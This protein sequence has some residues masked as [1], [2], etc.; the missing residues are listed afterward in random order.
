M[1]TAEKTALFSILTNLLLLSLKAGLA[2]ASGSLAIKADAI[3]SFSDVISSIIILVGIKISQ[4]STPSFPY[5]L[6]KLENL[7][8]L[9]T[10]LLIFYAGYEICQEVFTGSQPALDRLPLAV[11]GIGLTLLITLLFSRYELKKGK[12]TGSPSLIADAKHIWTDMLSSL[13]ILCSLIGGAVGYNLDKY[14]ALIV[15]LFILRS[16]IAIFLDSVR[17]LLDASLD[18]NTLNR[19][20]EVVMADSR[21][22]EVKNIWARNAGRYKFVELDLVLNIKDL[23]KGHHLS[24]ELVNRIKQKIEN[25][26]RILIHYQPRDRESL[27]LGIPLEAD[28]QKVSGHFG[29][30]PYFW[31]I[32]VLQVSGRVVEEYLL[33]NPYL[34]LERGKGIKVAQWLLAN[35]LDI[36]ITIH[37]Q[38]GKGPGYVLGNAGVEVLL[39][40]ETDPYKALAEVKA[41]L[42]LIPE[43]Q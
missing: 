8:A 39:T 7:V 3:H 29:E 12:E 38:E 2:F 42:G 20:R 31:L 26:D 28:R 21:V 6:Y 32:S 40:E 25:V 1:D 30:A 22:I 11:L 10:S 43:K 5:G 15:V 36:L 24:R 27:I 14:A 34:D 37:S 18:Y 19:I 4:R 35:K 23:E 16:A 9:G 41:Q 17:V 13:V 33:T